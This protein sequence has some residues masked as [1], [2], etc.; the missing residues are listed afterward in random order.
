MKLVFLDAK[1][2]GEDIDYSG[3]SRFG[4]VEKYDFSSRE[5]ARERLRDADCDL[6]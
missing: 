2:I 4:Q 6:E 3:F 1:S 5:E